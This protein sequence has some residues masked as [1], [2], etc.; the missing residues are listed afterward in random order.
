MR[1]LWSGRGGRVGFLGSFE[2][3]ASYYVFGLIAEV[4]R[5]FDEDVLCEVGFGL[6]EAKVDSS[7]AAFDSRGLGAAPLVITL[8][9]VKSI[10]FGRV[11]RQRRR[12][13]YSN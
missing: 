10:T 3:F 5:N 6:V 11:R 1:F 2:D 4:A 12:V 8:R 13:L 7:F 9:R